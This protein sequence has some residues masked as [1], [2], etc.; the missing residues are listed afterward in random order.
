MAKQFQGKVA[1]V[2]GASAGIGKATAI[3]F[4]REGARVIVAARWRH[5]PSQ[6]R[7]SMSLL[8]DAIPL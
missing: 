1:I 3:A 4:G 2:T 5:Q 8:A 7:G 6:S